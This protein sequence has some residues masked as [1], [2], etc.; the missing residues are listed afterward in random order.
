MQLSQDMARK[1]KTFVT[2]LGFFDLAVAA[3]SMKAAMEAWGLRRNLFKQGLASE[4]E[5][6]TI[7]A[8]AMAQPGRVL[9]RPVGT[10]VA[11]S[12]DADLPK[13]FSLP[14]TPQ[15]ISSAKTKVR[16]KAKEQKPS[17]RKPD[18]KVERSAVISFEKARAER[19][20]MRAKDVAAAERALEKRSSAVEKAQQAL[21]AAHKQHQS[22][23]E[24]LER[25]KTALDRQIEDEETRWTRERRK[26]EAAL[27]QARKN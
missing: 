27:D 16:P 4:T 18:P 19:E 20:R 25:E 21:D 5:D 8:A 1:L 13:G 22:R 11:F 9:R 14:T 10:S 2:T 15:A 3:P 6:P 17:G 24:K 12:E 7:V 23:R 26:L